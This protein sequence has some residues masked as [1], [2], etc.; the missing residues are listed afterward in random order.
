MK[1][2]LYEENQLDFFPL[3]PCTIDVNYSQE[4]I[5][6]PDGFI[7]NQIFIVNNGNGNVTINNNRYSVSKGDMFYIGAN[8]PHEYYGID[9]NF[10][11][12]Y[13]SFCGNGFENIKRY[14]DAGDF[15]IYNDKYA[16]S[17]E[18]QLKK[19]FECFDTQ[20]ELSYFCLAAF[21]TVT[22]FFDIACKK[23]YSPIETV[24]NYI[25]SN[26]SKMITLEDITAFY[27]FSKSKLCHDFR[28][29]YNMTIFEMLTKIRLTNARYMIQSNTN[30][31]LRQVAH[32]CGY[33]DTSYFCKLYKN[34]YGESPKKWI[35]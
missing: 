24:Y 22:A 15:G 11:T 5:S 18:A 35:K 29:K 30:I 14:Y 8:I 17:F 20:N 21:A 2:K 27:P 1:V 19:L 28:Q 10:K 6:R 3:Y 9:K 7:D 26:Y 25:E 16:I 13:L 34:F 12:S 32:S 23:E 31:K 33:N 4:K